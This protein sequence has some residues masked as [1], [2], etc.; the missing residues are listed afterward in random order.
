MQ[1]NTLQHCTK[2]CTHYSCKFFLC[3]VVY[4]YIIWLG[5]VDKSELPGKF[6][7]WI[8]QHGI[9]PR[10]L[11]PILVYDVPISTVEGFEIRVSRF[12]WKC[13]RLPQSLSSIA[14]YGQTNKL[15]LPISSLN[16][17][18]MLT[19]TREVLQYRVLR[20]KNLSG[21]DRGQDRTELEGSRGRRCC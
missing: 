19:R 12:L 16:E 18:F 14:L 15:K 9:L 21:W 11:W 2:C 5:V 3:F 10:I 13:L 7:A 1:T 4:Y 8:Y 17:E 6:K 20:P